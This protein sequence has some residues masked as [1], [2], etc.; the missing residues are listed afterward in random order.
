[1]VRPRLRL[2]SDDPITEVILLE[3]LVQNLVN[4]G[5]GTDCGYRLIQVRAARGA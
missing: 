1:M 3:R 5:C 2:P 4:H